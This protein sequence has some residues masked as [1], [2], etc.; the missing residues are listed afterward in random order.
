MVF[1]S[2]RFETINYSISQQMDNIVT[3][4]VEILRCRVVA[5]F[6]RVSHREKYRTACPNMDVAAQFRKVYGDYCFDL[7][8]KLKR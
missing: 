4:K 1:G 3:K 5:S 8:R 6:R 2:V 7:E